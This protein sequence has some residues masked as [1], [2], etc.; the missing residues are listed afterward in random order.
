MEI[1]RIIIAALRGG[2]GK[3]I[4]SI[5]II[6]AWTDLGKKVAPFKKGP[7]YIDAGWLALAAGRPCYNLDT[8]MIKEDQVLNSFLSHSINRDIAV[9]EGNRGLY[10]GLNVKGSTSTAELAKLLK[11][12][13]VLC[14]DCTKATRTM[15]AVVSGC[16]QFDPDVKIK[17]V[18]LNRIAGPRHEN[19]LRKSIEHYC[20][21][22]VLGA[23][24]KL[25]KQNFPER[26]MG[27]I[28][29]PEH[30]WAND[31]IETASQTASKYLDLDAIEK[32]ANESAKSSIIQQPA[33][34]P[35]CSRP[36]RQATSPPKDSGGQPAPRIG[37][38]KDSAFQFYYPENIEALISLGAE[39]VF[40]SPFSDSAIPPVDAL[41]IGGGFP[42][43][44]AKELTEKV[45]FKQQLKSLAE[46]GL[47][48]YAEC[49]G[50]MYLGKELVLDG[51]SYPM[52]DVLPVVFGLSK[53]PQGHGYTIIKVERENPYFKVGTEIRGHEF[54]Y[55]LILKWFGDDNDLAFN[56]KRGS[57][58]INKKDGICYK[59]VLATYTHIHA[60][61][62]PSWANAL[63]QNAV[64][65]KNKSKTTCV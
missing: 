40:I 38:I 61:G 21:V 39:T 55:S 43:T 33:T 37:I 25:A 60:L 13:V 17:G 27:L 54:H 12:P 42:E 52:A 32:I 3:T 18:I 23:V 24:P 7:D 30:T 29:T 31:S 20:G 35:P 57:G 49:G 53:R 64:S 9:I 59:N 45:A 47:P 5:G 4:I 58:F 16:M 2:A 19:I 62:T 65:Y 50:L 28:P 63:V 6:A 11:A 51:K 10:D 1:S 26:H 41:Y 56:M 46:D 36:S 22:P 15:A 8:F 14:I 44:H 34:S 48:I